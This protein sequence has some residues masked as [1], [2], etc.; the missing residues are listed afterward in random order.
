MYMEVFITS[1]QLPHWK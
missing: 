1:K